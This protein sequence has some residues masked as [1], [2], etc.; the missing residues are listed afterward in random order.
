MLRKVILC[1]S[2]LSS[3]LTFAAT[4]SQQEQFDKMV[5]AYLMD[6]PEVIIES[7]N[8]YQI[9]Q[10]QN[11]QI[12]AEK[13]A[14]TH[15][16]EIIGDKSI[17]TLGNPNAPITIVEFMDY[18]CG[19]CRKAH[20]MLTAVLKQHPKDVKVSIREF[21]ILGPQ[22]TEAAKL[23]LAAYQNS[24][25]K[26]VH[27][28]LFSKD[29]SFSKDGI[30]KIKKKYSLKINDSKIQEQLNSNFKLAEKLQ[31]S[32]TPAFIITNGKDVQVISGYIEAKQFSDIIKK[33]S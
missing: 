28:Y 11:S 33:M 20:E 8:Q 26:E 21:P 3:A 23:A 24:K 30:T 5:H 15:I 1:S 7:V 32:A 14:K 29:A 16:K 19:Y 31:I 6:H 12:E 17:P 22:S 27:S 18:R 4:E 13:Y 2:I 9:K 10:A 25:F